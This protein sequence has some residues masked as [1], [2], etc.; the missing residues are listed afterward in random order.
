MRSLESALLLY[1]WEGGIPTQTQT[2]IEERQQETKGTED[3]DEG[4]GRVT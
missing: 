2:C 1:D 3:E 4:R